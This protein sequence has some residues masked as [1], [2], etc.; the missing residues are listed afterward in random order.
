M[1][2]K[3]YITPVCTISVVNMQ[4]FLHKF[5]KV[6][7]YTNAVDL[8]ADQVGVAGIDLNNGASASEGVSFGRDRASV[9][10]DF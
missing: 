1:N 2:K 10:W 9:D 3:Q 4:T 8:S 7:V 6:E 5:S